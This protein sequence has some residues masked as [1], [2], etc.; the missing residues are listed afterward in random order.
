MKIVVASKSS[1]NDDLKSWD[2]GARNYLSSTSDE[3]DKFK[4]EIDNPAFIK[5]L[6]NL[7]GKRVLDIG[8]GGGYF[9]KK[10]T[11]LGA[12]AVGLDGSANMIDEAKKNYPE[13]TFVISD[14]TKQE[15]PFSEAEIDIVTGKMMLMNVNSVKQIAIKVFRV[16]RNQGLFAIDILHPFRPIVKSIENTGKYGNDLDYLKETTGTIEFNKERY[17]FYYR[18]ISMYVNEILDSGF[19]LLKMKE[20]GVDRK[21]VNENPDQKGKLNC[22]ISLHL[23]FRKSTK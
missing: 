15:L 3:N 19:S 5:L 23:L 2:L 20:L 12:K 18:P 14:L 22:P 17:V 21:F 4:S 1:M 11:D 9:V 10:L 8:C 13:C 6:G 16:L 7:N